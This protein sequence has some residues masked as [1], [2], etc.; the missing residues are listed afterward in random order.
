[1][2]DFSRSPS[3]ML[4][5]SQQQ[6]YLG[7]HI[8]QGVPVLDR[9][10]NL[11]HDLL[12]AR[13]SSA[14][15]R[16]IGDG[17]PAGADGFAVKAL[18]APENIGNFSITAGQDGQPGTCLVA[19]MEVTIRTATTYLRQRPAP[20][21]LSTPTPP[22][23]NPR[24][25]LV[26]LDVSV[27]EVN[28]AA[29]HDLAN[30][31]D[32][33]MQTSVRLKLDWTVRVAEGRPIPQPEAGHSFYPLAELRRPHGTD[34][35]DDSMITDLRQH[36]LTVSDLEQ[37]LTVLEAVLL[38]P[39]F[40]QP[41]EPQIVPRR[42]AIGSK[43]M[44]SGTNFGNG[45]MT[46]FFRDKKAEIADRP[47]AHK[48][49]VLIPPGL[50]PAG[51]DT[52]VRVTVSNQIG[53]TTSTE[54]FKVV[55]APAFGERGRQLEPPRLA[56][57][58]RLTIN[59]FNLT[60]PNLR[61]VFVTSP[62]E[63]P[64]DQVVERTSTKIVVEVPAGTLPDNQLATTIPVILRS[65]DREVRSDD[66]LRIE[67]RD[68]E[69]AFGDPEFNPSTARVGQTIR[70]TGRNFQFAPRVSFDYINRGTVRAPNA[71]TAPN[72]ID[73][74]VPPPAGGGGLGLGI[75]ATITVETDA[76]SV[77]STRQIVVT[78]SA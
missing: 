26:Y 20:V 53:S 23:P 41:P 35:I 32:V 70:L 34:T 50:T 57:G 62:N 76:G 31:R 2:G 36:R 33:G 71:T 39:T 42:G 73:V 49:Q 67:R 56:P 8:E 1:M 51:T 65:G 69:P 11:L 28:A 66:M 5:A 37:R 52:D 13:I 64:A 29:D 18:E 16:H 4:A 22:Q 40:A 21:A 47:S 46:V 3:E 78:G 58:D 61:V 68:V 75:A 60:A 15:A 63:T 17:L 27:T 30:P 7:L 44:L 77:T 12:A 19:G 48:L 72:G 14:F 45:S 59:G 10:L 9:D 55:A 25:D 38:R 74:Q 54:T 43:V 24:R 6:G